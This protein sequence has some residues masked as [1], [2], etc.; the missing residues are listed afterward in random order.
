MPSDFEN[1]GISI[2]EAFSV[3]LPVVV[4]NKTPWVKIEEDRM[5]WVVDNNYQ[6][7]N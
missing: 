6:S 5:G 1:F 3:G 7:I 2:L 4:S